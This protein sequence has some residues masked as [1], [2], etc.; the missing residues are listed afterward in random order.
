MGIFLEFSLLNMNSL[1]DVAIT[2][3]PFNGFLLFLFVLV[4]RVFHFNVDMFVI[5]SLWLMFIFFL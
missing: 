3:S 4:N 5:F 1:L 2:F